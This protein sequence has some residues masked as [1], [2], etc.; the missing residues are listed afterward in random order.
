MKLLHL[1]DLHIDRAF[2]GAAFEGCDSGQRRGL[3]RQALQWAVPEDN[4]AQLLVVHAV[5]LDRMGDGLEWGGLGLRRADV[6]GAG[7]KHALLG[8]IHAG[9]VGDVMS[10]PGSP[11][12]LDPSETSGNHGAL[13]V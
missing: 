11:V 1:A 13:L 10:W 9:A 6:T 4:R 2:G 7:F 5:D 3:L 12:P 8:H